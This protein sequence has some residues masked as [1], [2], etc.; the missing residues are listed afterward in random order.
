MDL[1]DLKATGVEGFFVVSAVTGAKD[2]YRAA[3]EL[4]EGWERAN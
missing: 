4:V 3:K 1:A 2:S